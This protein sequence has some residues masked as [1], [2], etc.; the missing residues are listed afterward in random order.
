MWIKQYCAKR[1]NYFLPQSIQVRNN[2]W[3]YM[4]TLYICRMQYPLA[5]HY[6]ELAFSFFFVIME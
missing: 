2:E 4:I 6:L 3:K 1:E 5:A